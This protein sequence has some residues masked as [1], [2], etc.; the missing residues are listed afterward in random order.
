MGPQKTEV[1]WMDSEFCKKTKFSLVIFPLDCPNCNCN[2]CTFKPIENANKLIHLT[3]FSLPQKIADDLGVEMKKIMLIFIISISLI[4]NIYA[5][6][7]TPPDEWIFD[8]PGGK[9]GV[10]SFHSRYSFI[11]LADKQITIRQNFKTT[12]AIF[13]GAFIV[14]IL[15]LTTVPI[16]SLWKIKKRSFKQVSPTESESPPLN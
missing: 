6:L 5:Y 7:Y 10:Y 3:I 9:Y 2:L 1:V 15:I 11:I 14:F 13:I 8:G 4:P 16:Y 12:K